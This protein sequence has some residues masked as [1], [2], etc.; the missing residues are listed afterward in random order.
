MLAFYEAFSQNLGLHICNT[1]A[2]K[3]LSTQ[4]GRKHSVKVTTSSSAWKTKAGLSPQAS[5]IKAVW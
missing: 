5:A 2:P 3:V 1:N 4:L